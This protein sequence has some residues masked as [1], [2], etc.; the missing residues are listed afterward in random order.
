MPVEN[1]YQSP[2]GPAELATAAE[3]EPVWISSIGHLEAFER[4]YWKT[5][6]LRRHAGAFDL[7]DGFPYLRGVCMWKVPLVFYASGQ[8]QIE[9][10]RIAFCARP[11]KLPMNSLRNLTEDF[12]F[13][14]T[15]DEIESIK[16]FEFHSPVARYFNLVFVRIQT[17]LAAE[18]ADVLMC[19]GGGGPFMGKLRRRNKQFYGEISAAFPEL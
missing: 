7:P 12:E 6:F 18:L 10:N 15:N 2:R 5:S 11:F 19:I 9:R 8:L 14:L 13:A 4:A 1:P 16:L 3:F 17:N